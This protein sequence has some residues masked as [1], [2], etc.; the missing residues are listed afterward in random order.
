MHIRRF[1]DSLGYERNLD[2]QQIRQNYS[3]SWDAARILASLNA[4]VFLLDKLLEDR[5]GVDDD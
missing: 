3:M 5:D 4:V 2:P 1:T